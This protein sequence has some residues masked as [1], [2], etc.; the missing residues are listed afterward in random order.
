MTLVASTVALSGDAGA[1]LAPVLP[2]DEAF[3]KLAIEEAAEAA[4]PF[5]AVIVKNGDVLAR[6]H[7]RTGVDHD[8]TAHGEMVAI[9]AFLAAH[10]PEALKG[11]TLYTSGE[12]C[13]MC[14]GAIIWCGIGRL[15]YAASVKQLSTKL[16]QIALSAEDVAEKAPF[17]PIDIVGGVL[18]NEAMRL[19]K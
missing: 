18:A 19:F 6:G 13:C 3:M 7:N 4:F 17:A 9:R 8:P 15:V 14:M 2:E 16:D 5:G 10:G 12:P 1:R 11:T